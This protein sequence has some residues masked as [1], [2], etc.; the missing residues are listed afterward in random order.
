MQSLK[1]LFN[2]QNSTDMMIVVILLMY[3]LVDVKTPDSLAEIV[4]NIFGQIVIIL[5]AMTLFTKCHPLVGVLALFAAYQLIMRSSKATGTYAVENIMPSEENKYEEMIEQNVIPK[6]LEEEV[7][8]T[9][10]PLTRDLPNGQQ[11]YQPVLDSNIDSS[12]L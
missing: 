9:M 1:S 8:K 4:D 11:T 12:M 7:V 3:V 5:G 6:T 2:Q 10:V